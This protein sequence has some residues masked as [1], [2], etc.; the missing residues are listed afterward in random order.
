MNK[1]DFYNASRTAARVRR[2]LLKRLGVDGAHSGLCGV[3]ALPLCAELRLKGFERC[4]IVYG[5]IRLD[6]PKINRPHYW[7]EIDGFVIDITADQ[8]NAA[9][10]GQKFP[11]VVLA[12]YQL[13]PRYKPDRKDAIPLT[14]TPEGFLQEW[15]QTLT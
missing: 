9:I 8:F 15:L 5:Y 1:R 3:A 14:G 4:F 11:G 13:L 2:L 6:K 12:P 7:V 10:T